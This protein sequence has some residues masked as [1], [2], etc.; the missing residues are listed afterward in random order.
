MAGFAP[1]FV[2]FFGRY[3]L[4]TLAAYL[5]LCFNAVSNVFDT[6]CGFIII[7]KRASLSYPL[8]ITNTY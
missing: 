1:L 6:L 3:A 5:L 4:V 2:L 8:F 7:K